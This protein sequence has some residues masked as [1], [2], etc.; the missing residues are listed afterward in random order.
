[1]LEELCAQAPLIGFNSGRYDLNLVKNDLLAVLGADNIK[2]V[3]KN[4]SYM[5]ISTNDLNILD[6]SNYLPPAIS[7]EKYLNPPTTD[8]VSYSML[9]F[10]RWCIYS[11]FK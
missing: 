6:I 5:C 11:M 2:M 4:P 9:G 7:Y 8:V 1:L 10:I 3:I